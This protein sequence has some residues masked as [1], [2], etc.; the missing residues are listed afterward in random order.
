MGRA[1]KS[2]GMVESVE[3]F[4]SAI[5]LVSSY[6]G[7][8][9]GICKMHAKMPPS[10]GI[11]LRDAQV[12]SVR[13]KYEPKSRKMMQT[14]RIVCSAKQAK[15]LQ[16][17]AL[18]FFEKVIVPAFKLSQT[19]EDDTLIY[20]TARQATLNIGCEL[21]IGFGENLPKDKPTGFF[22]EKNGVKL[23][24]TMADLRKFLVV[25]T[26]KDEDTQ[27]DVEQPVTPWIGDIIINF[28]TTNVTANEST[29]PKRSFKA[30]QNG[31]T[32]M[33]A[34]T[35]A[36]MDFRTFFALD[37]CLLKNEMSST[38]LAE[39][40]GKLVWRDIEA[41][42]DESDDEEDAAAADAPDD[43]VAPAPPAKKPR[44]ISNDP[45]PEASEGSDA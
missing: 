19:N 13:E 6:V 1:R 43:A 23:P 5:G 20:E 14:V 2:N 40:A 15:M 24:Q 30:V 18:I 17:F 42:Y 7:L 36:A 35:T 27:Q 28:A 32:H 21:I 9:A 33:M 8:G 37:K 10:T 22:V 12:V 39:A 29:D 4:Q 3:D 11:L 16:D 31:A 45:S 44:V 25:T 38:E 41:G 26:K 34:V